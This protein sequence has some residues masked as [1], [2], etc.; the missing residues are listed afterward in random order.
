MPLKGELTSLYSLSSLDLWYHVHKTAFWVASCTWLLRK[1]ASKSLREVT[2]SVYVIYLI[3][4]KMLHTIGYLAPLV[5]IITS[6]I[7]LIKSV[8]KNV[9]IK[10]LGFYNPKTFTVYPQ[11]L[12]KY[13]QIGSFYSK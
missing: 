10:G 5:E 7:D 11:G 4:L 9:N 8:T 13:K 1:V 3:S 6:S 12:Y 2:R